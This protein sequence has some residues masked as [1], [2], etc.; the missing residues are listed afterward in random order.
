MGER[1]RMRC[2]GTWLRDDCDPRHPIPNP[3]EAHWLSCPGRQAALAESSV[4]ADTEA[5]VRRGMMAT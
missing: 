5:T 2:C 3:V 4:A 1:L